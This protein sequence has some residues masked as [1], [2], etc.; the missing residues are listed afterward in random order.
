MPREIFLQNLAKL[1]NKVCVLGYGVEENLAK[2]V[3]AFI[4][5]NSKQAQQ[6]IDYDL[7]VNQQRVEIVIECLTLIATQQPTG[8]DLR[9]LAANIE[10]AGELERIHDYIKGIGRVI[11]DRSDQEIPTE[12]QDRFMKMVT[13]T[14]GMLHAA[15][16]SFNAVT[17]ET[18]RDIPNRDRE[19]DKLFWEGSHELA[20][21]VTEDESTYQK[22]HT[23]QLVLNYLER[24]GD[25]VTNIC[26]WIIYKGTGDYHEIN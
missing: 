20:I 7:V 16:E 24:T 12:T 23:L 1:E 26:E 8:A 3:T 5:H 9:S 25:R 4:E 11:L 10:I 14:R 21:A 18:A 17:V 2:S 22:Y 13:I 19:V 6:L 15:I